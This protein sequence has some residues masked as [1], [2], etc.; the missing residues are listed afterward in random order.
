VAI[1]ANALE[2]NTTGYDNVAVGVNAL[3]T[4]TT[5]NFSNAYGDDALWVASGSDNN[6][7][8]F[9]AG[10]QVTS[11]SFNILIGENANITTGS[12]NIV[13]GNSLTGTAATGNGQID[14]GDQII[15]A[16]GVTT[17]TSPLVMRLP[18]TTVAA[19]PSCGA[20]RLGEMYAVSDA[21][22]PTYNAPV[23]SGGS[24]TIPVFCNG[25]AWTA[26]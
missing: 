6:A 23:S 1:G 3:N 25:S 22:T 4:T 19:L 12:N 8:G 21:A 2:A 26:H 15:V 16:N 17:L 13:I 18:V 10:A 9:Q 7:F 24:S 20:G 5:S 14:I 11:G